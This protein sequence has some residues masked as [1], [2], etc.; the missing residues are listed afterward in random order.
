MSHIWGIL[1][2]HE[3][4]LP[5]SA[6]RDLKAVILGIGAGLS[7]ERSDGARELMVGD[8]LDKTRNLVPEARGHT[9]PEQVRDYRKR[10]CGVEGVEDHGL[11]PRSLC[12]REKGCNVEK[13]RADVIR[14]S[15]RAIQRVV[16]S[17]NVCRGKNC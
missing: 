4:T 2:V 5:C 13:E 1:C 17:R 16:G 9:K 12:T 11:Q 8:G 15:A 14:M 7:S 10:R 3:R 6:G